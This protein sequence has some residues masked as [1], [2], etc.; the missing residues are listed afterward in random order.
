MASLAM[1][2]L[3][4]IGL[5]VQVGDFITIVSLRLKI[6]FAQFSVRFK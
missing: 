5:V 4:V 1:T 6:K 2:I 3:F